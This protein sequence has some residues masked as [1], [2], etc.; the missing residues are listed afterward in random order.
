MLYHYNENYVVNE[1]GEC[2]SSFHGRLRKL[3]PRISS[4]GYAEYR[5]R[6]GGKTVTKSAHYLSYKMARKTAWL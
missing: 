5:L 3:K 6:L 1:C 4:K 2:F